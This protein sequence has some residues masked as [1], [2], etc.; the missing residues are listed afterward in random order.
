MV[1]IVVVGIY[2]GLR[3]KKPILPLSA[4]IFIVGVICG[5]LCLSHLRADFSAFTLPKET[6]MPVK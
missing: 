6:G 3:A 4:C 2:I 5:D 1:F